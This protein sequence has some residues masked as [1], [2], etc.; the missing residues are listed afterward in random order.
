MTFRRR[1]TLRWGSP[2]PLLQAVLGLL[3]G[4][5]PAL[6]QQSPALLNVSTRGHVGTDANMMIAGLVI[7]GP[8]SSSRRILLR[9]LGPSL[10]AFNVSGALSNPRLILNSGSSEIDRNDDWESN[11]A[12]AQVARD[13]GLSPS[14]P[15][16]C[17]LVR[18]LAP[19]AYTAFVEGVGGAT[20]IALV[21]A[22][23]L[24]TRDSTAPSD[25]RVVN[26]STRGRVAA[27]DNVMIM[28]FVIAGSEPRNV[29]IAAKAGS[30]VEFGV[31][32]PLSDSSIEIFAGDNVTKLG[33]S[34]DWITQ[35]NFEAIARTGNA[36][37]DPFESAVLLRLNPGTYTAV[38]RGVDG[39]EGV[40][41]PELYE[42][43][44]D[45][46][47]RFSPTG[48]ADRTATLV[49]STGGQAERLDLTFT[50]GAVATVGTGTA[51][52]YTYT[53]A[54]DYR[55]TVKVEA[56]GYTIDGTL[57]FYR[58]NVAYFEGTLQKAGGSAQTSGGIFI[59]R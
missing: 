15:R 49:V 22:Y 1:A 28:G 6:A 23:D 53:A 46:G 24:D 40:A 43:R 16:E 35:E 7:E 26:L 41:I 18:T 3:L 8:P 37:L 52:T 58:A 13:V 17:I 30:L 25:S 54:S 27:G 36:P 44:S 21:E 12:M 51:G 38:V 10:S 19:G 34:N 57:Q 32:N 29:L 59:V 56:S 9:V 42:L 39:A 2:L 5:L 31:S 20:G 45:T 48:L 33:E 50:G 55:A 11:A 4:T 14:S 47:V